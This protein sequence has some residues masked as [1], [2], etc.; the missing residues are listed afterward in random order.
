MYQNPRKARRRWGIITRVL[1]KTRETVWA[2]GMMYKVVAQLVLLY[3]SEIWVT[4]GDML[5]VLEGFHHREARRIMGM[6]ETRGAGGE[7]EYPLVVAEMEAAGLHPIRDYIRRRQSTIAENVACLPIDEI[8]SKE[9]EMPG[10]SRIVR[11]WD[12]DVVNE[13]EE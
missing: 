1:E 5:K 7:W 2:R 6:A 13:P 4:T 12:Q 10:T 9:E 8:Y 11:W 3:G